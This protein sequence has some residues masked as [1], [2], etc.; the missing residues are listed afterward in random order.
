MKKNNFKENLRKY[1]ENL[2]LS[3]KEFAEKLDINATTYRNYENS[4]REPDYDTL[5]KI[6][7]ALDVSI[8]TLLGVNSNIK[9]SNNNGILNQYAPIFEELSDENKLAVIT[10]I[11]SLHNA[12]TLT[13][14]KNS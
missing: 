5:I 13:K 11:K 14:R 9:A 10:M 4:S 1:R 12:A 6:A 7:N 2:N 3:Q 8:D